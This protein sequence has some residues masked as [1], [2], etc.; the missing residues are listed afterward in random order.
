MCTAS[1]ARATQVQPGQRGRS[2][3]RRPDP[4]G[5]VW[6]RPVWRMQRA[7]S[8]RNAWAWAWRMHCAAVEALGS[9]CLT[10]SHT[11]GGVKP[12][13]GVH[14]PTA[15]HRTVCKS[16]PVNHASN[17]LVWQALPA[18]QGRGSWKLF[19]A[20]RRQAA[21]PWPGGCRGSVLSAEL[22]AGHC[23]GVIMCCPAAPAPRT[24]ASSG[25]GILLS[26]RATRPSRRSP[27]ARR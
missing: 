24:A 7:R 22:C 3:I 12:T 4:W 16:Q 6:S 11:S 8:S 9:P 27:A 25:A 13:R 23:S 10:T 15:L 2:P 14:Q 17:T 26:T 1:T 21:Q 20:G 5:A 19:P 18:T